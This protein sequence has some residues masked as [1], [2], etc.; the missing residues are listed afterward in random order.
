MVIKLGREIGN[1]QRLFLAVVGQSDKCAVATGDLSL[2][3]PRLNY[4]FFFTN[5][6]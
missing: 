4:N 3:T 1:S 6:F 2:T 5:Q